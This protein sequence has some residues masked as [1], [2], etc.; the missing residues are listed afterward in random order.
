MEDYQPFN[1]VPV[2]ATSNNPIQTI[3][4]YQPPRTMD[5]L[6]IIKQIMQE[7]S[8]G[9]VEQIVPSDINITRV[10]NIP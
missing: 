7:V 6:T 8:S 9:A 1:Q 4:V 2:E 3:V 5:M 10:G